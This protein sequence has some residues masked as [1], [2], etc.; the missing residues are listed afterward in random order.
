MT[1]TIL[2][3]QDVLDLSTEIVICSI[4]FVF[5]LTGAAIDLTGEALTSRGLKAYCRFSKSETA[6]PLYSGKSK[7]KNRKMQ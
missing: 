2:G 6:K 7:R 3:K 5:A 4:G 1:T